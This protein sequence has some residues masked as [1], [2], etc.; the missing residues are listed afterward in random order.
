MNLSTSARTSSKL[1]GKDYDWGKT[2]SLNLSLSIK[3][4]FY[5]GSFVAATCL[6]HGGANWINLGRLWNSE[7]NVKYM[8]LSFFVSWM[9]YMCNLGYKAKSSELN[10]QLVLLCLELNKYLCNLGYEIKSSK[11]SVMSWIENMCNLEYKVNICK[12]N[13]HLVLLCLEL[14][15][16]MLNAHL[17]THETWRSQQ[18][19]PSQMFT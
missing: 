11:S 8:S 4:I 6:S 13:V 12:L 10:V 9:K 19:S 2:V 3:I 16:Y 15:K 17:N 7:L 1:H 18:R 5:A 14:N